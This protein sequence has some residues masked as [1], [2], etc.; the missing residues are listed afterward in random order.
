MHFGIFIE[1]RRRGVSEADAFREAME[2]VDA[3][4]SWGLD[5]VWLG[6]IHFNGMR[7]VQSSP[8]TLSAYIAARTRRVRIG[9]WGRCSGV[10]VTGPVLKRKYSPS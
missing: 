3:S 1:E 8:L 2:L 5:G 4:E 9:G 7:S 10:G 6:E